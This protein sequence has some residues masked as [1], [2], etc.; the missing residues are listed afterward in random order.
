[1]KIAYHFTIPPPPRPELDAA[2]Q[3]ALKLKQ[4]YAGELNYLYPGREAKLYIPRALCGWHQLTELTA[5]DR[6][7]DIH[8]IYSNGLYPYPIL[9]RLNKPVVFTAITGSRWPHLLLFRP[10]TGAVD[11]IVTSNPADK[12]RL[13]RWGLQNVTVVWPGIDLSRF[14]HTPTPNGSKFVLMAGSAPWDRGQFKT[15]GVD[16]LLAAMHE[17]PD[18]HLI[19]LWRGRLLPEL[20]ARIRQ[21]NV[22]DRIEVINRQV[23]VNEV[24]ARSHASIV[25]AQEPNIVKAYPHSLIESLA[26]GK[27]VLVSRRLAM[28]G[29]VAETGCGEIIEELRLEQFLV[30]LALL[31]QNYQ[32][33]QNKV[34]K[35][36]M[37]RFSVENLIESYGKIYRRILE[38]AG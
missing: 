3:D 21:Q 31:R 36:D 22:A 16:L 1:M 37:G 13:M 4:H 14:K 15:K 11:T 38:A 27:P 28:A 34:L 9:R 26:A 32:T 6:Q 30:K 7:V 33:Y 10:L 24:L 8:Q 23:D 5:L 29:Y 20:E 17:M 19:M 18:L 12:E 35:L 2:I 25:L